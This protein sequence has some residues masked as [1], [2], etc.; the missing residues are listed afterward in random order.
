MKIFN[1]FL[2]N[3]SP[4]T[5]LLK[6][7]IKLNHYK[8]WLI[9]VQHGYLQK[10]RKNVN[11]VDKER[12]NK[13][14]INALFFSHVEGY[15]FAIQEEEINTNN[16]KNKRDKKHNINPKCQLCHAEKETIQHIIAACPKLRASMYLP[17]RHN[18]VAKIIYD[19]VIQ[20]NDIDNRMIPLQQKYTDE[21]VEI[22]WDNKIKTIPWLQ[23]NKPV[24]VIW[25]KIGKTCFIFSFFHFIYSFPPYQINTIQTLLL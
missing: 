9:K 15:L 20:R 24:L 22:W 4:P 17:V 23:H 5:K 8:A 2:E 6:N 11:K 25:Y 10:T 1:V 13:W 12:T 18:K 16:L 21:F 14:L 3:D 7:E 19:C